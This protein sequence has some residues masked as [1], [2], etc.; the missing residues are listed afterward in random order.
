MEVLVKSV[1]FTPQ[2]ATASVGGPVQVAPSLHQPLATP[3][4]A[5]TVEC[6]LTAKMGSHI[7]V[8]AL[9]VSKVRLVNKSII[10]VIQTPA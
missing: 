9:R 7:R 5:K 3:T 1:I 8:H 6:V 4:L 2:T 10:R